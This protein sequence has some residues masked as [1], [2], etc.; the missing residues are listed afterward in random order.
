[1]GRQ[2]QAVRRMQEMFEH[3]WNLD[4]L[5]NLSWMSGQRVSSLLTAVLDLK[6]QNLELSLLN[7][8]PSWATHYLV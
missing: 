6:A 4:K 1:M 8:N 7:S 3:E 5:I 2:R